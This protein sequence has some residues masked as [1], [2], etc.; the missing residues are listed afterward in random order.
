MLFVPITD[1][2]ELLGE[3][4]HLVGR[5]R[6]G[7]HA[8][9]ASGRRASTAPE[10]G[11]GPVERLVP[12][13]GTQRAVLAHQRFGQPTAV[14]SQSDHPLSMFSGAS[15]STL[16]SRGALES[17]AGAVSVT[18]MLKPVMLTPEGSSRGLVPFSHEPDREGAIASVMRSGTSGHRSARTLSRRGR[19]RPGG[20]A[21][22][23]HVL[24]PLPRAVPR[25]PGPDSS[26]AGVRAGR[27]LRRAHARAR[28]RVRPAR[29]RRGV[30]RERGRER[31][32]R[33][34][35]HRRH[36]SDPDRPGR[37]EDA[38]ARARQQHGAV[39]VLVGV[40]DGHERDGHRA[41]GARDRC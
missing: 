23:G 39:V 2:D 19:P 26:A 3:E 6:A 13:R 17:Q 16:T 14:L 36:G 37:Q 35:R 4:V 8:E 32:R 21:R 24:V 12:G 15:A 25:R 28:D 7:E 27:V 9:R 34:H 20:P 18:R 5:L 11:R 10:P 22:G 41:R 30:D 33:R 38:A 40:G 31:R 29:R 1:A